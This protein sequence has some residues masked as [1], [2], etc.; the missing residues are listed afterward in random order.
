MKPFT[1]THITT[2]H[3]PF[4]IRI[5][6]KECKS[7]ARHGLKI[8]L[9]ATHHKEETIDKVNI[10]PLPHFKN[11]STRILLKPFLAFLKALKTHA[12][13]FHFHDPELILI[14]LFLK[15]A[16]KKVIYD[17]HED[18]PSQILAKHWIP[19]PLRRLISTIVQGIEALCS[20]FFDGIVAATPFIKTIFLKRNKNTIDV[21][22]Y[23]LSKEAALFHFPNKEKN[24]QKKVICYV[25]AITKE[26][27]ILNL[28]KA[29]ED[30]DV[31][32]YL[33]G[34][35]SPKDLIKDLEKEKGWKNVNYFGQLGRNKLADIFSQSQVG[36]CV[37]YP[38]P[39]HINSNPTK[40]F[41]YMCAGLPIIASN[42]PHWKDLTA[43]YDNVVFVDPLNA[44]EISNAINNLL[45]DPKQCR[46]MG[47][48]GR[49]AI[50]E[51]YHWGTEEKKLVDFY[52]AMLKS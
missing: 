22:N 29:I 17:V 50:K 43:N 2:A 27:G 33:A 11:R 30:T 5:F 48:R 51:K 8:N 16:G 46:A 37:L 36:M 47:E 24:Q 35:C 19:C 26:R 49:Q 7:L 4:D 18:V 39:N 44:Q 41:E 14:G 25:G 31:K 52:K 28:L 10:I 40:L 1:V 15:L 12:D 21:N 38:T 34:T 13:V 20:R 32:L 9:I 45:N 23:P 3:P 6:H 42:F